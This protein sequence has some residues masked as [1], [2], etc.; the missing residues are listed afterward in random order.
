MCRLGEA[1]IREWLGRKY[2]SSL[3]AGPYDAE[4]GYAEVEGLTD[5]EPAPG[6]ELRH[7]SS[8]A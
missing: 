8:Q 4:A 1:W 2:G 7:S 5:E 6:Y 3:H